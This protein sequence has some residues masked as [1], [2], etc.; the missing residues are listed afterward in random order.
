MNG[1][2]SKAQLALPFMEKTT[3]IE[4]VTKFFDSIEDMNYG[5]CGI[6]ALGMYLYLKKYKLHS[7]FVL[8]ALSNTESYHLQN[9]AY[10][11]GKTSQGRSS[12]HFCYEIDGVV[13]RY[14]ETDYELRIETR[15]EEFLT[16]I[17]LNS[18]WN[19]SF[20]RKKYCPLI[21]KTLGI[22]LPVNTY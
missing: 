21:E 12:T 9:L 18:V 5:G 3:R 2:L 8:I 4:K 1:I 20:E 6:A 17:I 15:V 7:D 10:V 22:K 16:D 11:Q 19:D 14:M 13:H